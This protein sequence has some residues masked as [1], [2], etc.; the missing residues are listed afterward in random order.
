MVAVRRVALGLF[1][2]LAVA[3][4]LFGFALNSI[5]EVLALAHYKAIAIFS[6]IV[7]RASS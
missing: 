1:I 3:L 4:I 6:P 5:I 2:I 7:E